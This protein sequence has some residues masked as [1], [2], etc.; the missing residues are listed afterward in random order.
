[1]KK[2]FYLLFFIANSI[3][4]QAQ[5][6]QSLSYYATNSD[7]LK[8]GA[9]VGGNFYSNTVY[10]TGGTFDTTIKKNFNILVPE[11]EMKFD[12]I[13]PQ[14]GVFNFINPDKLVAYAQ[15]YGMQVR[16]HNL[17]WHSQ[18]PVWVNSGLTNGIANGTFTRESLMGVL[19]NHITSVVGRYKGRIQQWDVLNEPFNDGT[20]T[21]RASVW[22]Q[23]IGNDY[24]DSVFVWTHRTDP[25]AKLYLNEYGDEY[26]GDTKSNAVYN[27][28]KAMKERGIPVNGVGLQCHFTANSINFSSLDQNIKR[29]AAIGLEAI[30]TELDIK[31]KKTDFEADPVKWLGYQ[32]EDYRRMILLSLNNS[33]CKIFLTWGFTDLYSWIP[34]FTNNVYDYALI[35]DSDLIAKPAYTSI[36]KELASTGGGT[37]VKEISN[38]ENL[39]FSITNDIA[40]VET[41]DLILNCELVDMQGK[42]QKIQLTGTNTIEFNLITRQS[43]IYILKIQLINGQ[44]ITHKFIH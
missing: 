19:K 14:K 35:F 13:E 27:Y 9:A 38:V 29:Y 18:L 33:N 42:V 28:V 5:L 3:L 43:K 26:V 10:D 17:C 8:I 21:L 6:Q 39:K 25:I 32:A 36:L 15:K 40:Y 22:Q 41:T 16:G 2:S 30:I 4:I 44:L 12:A 24:I 1:M 7:S 31:I 37:S 11:N 23:V 34:S 20:G